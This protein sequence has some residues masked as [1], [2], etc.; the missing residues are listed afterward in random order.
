MPGSELE[1]GDAVEPAC[2]MSTSREG[3]PVV[4]RQ[5]AGDVEQG[6]GNGRAFPIDEYEAAPPSMRLEP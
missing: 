2:S 5:Y 6:I 3:G 4:V 1:A